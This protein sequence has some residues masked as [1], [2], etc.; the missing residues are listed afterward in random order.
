MIEPIDVD[1]PQVEE[2]GLIDE[3]EKILEAS[4]A[5][6][7]KDLGVLKNSKLIK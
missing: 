5:K 3:G 6:K 1:D 7:L 4:W 2:M